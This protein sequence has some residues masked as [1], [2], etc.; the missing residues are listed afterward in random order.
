PPWSIAEILAV[1]FRMHKAEGVLWREALATASAACD[2]QVVPVSE[3]RLGDEARTVLGTTPAGV[4]KR[5]AALGRDIG[6]PWGKD[7]KD[8]A[9]AALIALASAGRR[10]G[11]RR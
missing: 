10:A 9:L 3:K 7:Q 8:A 5:L 11:K 2:L 4:Q 6:P 1:H